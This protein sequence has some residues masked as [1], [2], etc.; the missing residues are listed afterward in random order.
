MNDSY[1]QELADW[2]EKRPAKQPRQDK[3]VVAFLAVRDDVKA[4]LDAGYA[5]K[6]IWQHMSETGRIASRYETFTLH[7]KRF[8]T[9][10][11]PTPKPTQSKQKT[12]PGSSTK[13]AALSEPSTP[14]TEQPVSASLPKEPKKVTISGFSF[15]PVPKKDDL[16]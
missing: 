14:K 7:V 1:M 12:T 13:T 3:H 6:T 5:M 10:A 9:E 16:L 4:A 11:A 8:I 2:A 15:D